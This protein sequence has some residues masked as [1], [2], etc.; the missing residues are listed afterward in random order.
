MTRRV[1]PVVLVAALAS[2]NPAPPPPAPTRP[3]AAAAATTAPDTPRAPIAPTPGVLYDR[4]SAFNRVRVTQDAAGLRT[5]T[6]DDPRVRQT[7][8]HPDRPHAL[9]LTYTQ[10]MSTS[11]CL[12][13]APKNVLVVGLG[14]G[15]LPSFLHHHYSDVRVT[16]AELDPDVIA[17]AKTYFGFRED[18][19]MRAVPGD[20]RAFVEKSPDRYDLILLDA[21][22]PESIPLPLATRQFLEAVRSRLAP[23]GVV[24]ANIPGPSANTLY[25]RMLATYRAV[26][27]QLHLVQAPGSVQQTLIALPA[28]DPAAT[29]ASLVTAA[30]DLQRRHR[31]PHDLP[32]LLDDGYRPL[33]DAPPDAKPL[34]DNEP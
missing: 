13:P 15:A 14:G 1:P 7:V 25:H 21:Y 33:P 6:F 4:Q 9:V 5:L 11:L 18:P 27:P 3:P 2:C 30:R 22:G 28:A 19:R 23:G 29:K 17:V 31:F 20:G 34:L 16:A 32:A 24:A 26:F 8:L 12:N 10:A